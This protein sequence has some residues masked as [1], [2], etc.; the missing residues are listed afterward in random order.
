MASKCDSCKL[1]HKRVDG[2]KIMCKYRGKTH[3][4]REECNRYIANKVNFDLLD[5]VG[6]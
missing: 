3:Q 6:V 4:R 5:W 1:L 2:R